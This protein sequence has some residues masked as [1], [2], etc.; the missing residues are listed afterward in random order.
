MGGHLVVVAITD[1]AFPR[2]VIEADASAWRLLI[3]LAEA[4]D[5]NVRC[6]RRS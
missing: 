3:R 1:V 6:S 2:S 5:Y 4:S